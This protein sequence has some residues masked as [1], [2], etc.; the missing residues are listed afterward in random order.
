M[1]NSNKLLL[2]GFLLLLLL[3]SA[4]HIT[5]FA[6]YKNGEY[7]VYNSEST[8]TMDAGQPLP[9]IKFVTIRNVR[10][11]TIELGN[12]AKLTKDAGLTY[13]QNGDTLLIN[14][15]EN[16][17]QGDISHLVLALPYNATVSIINS[18]ITVKTGNEDTANKSV[19]YLSDSR[20]FFS[21]SGS[22]TD[23]GNMKIVATKNSVATFEHG[24]HVS[25]LGVELSNS[26]LE[27]ADGNFG[28]LSIITDSVSQISLQSKNLLKAKISTNP[29]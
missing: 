22:L 5:L 4:I 6:K 13:V 7:T 15:K 21:G 1:K 16:L 3:I 27:D 26:S 17:N 23:F 9:N 29:K 8:V 28:Q 18:S 2:G 10:G 24:M 12:V 25:N 14:A 11:A 20:A 19:V